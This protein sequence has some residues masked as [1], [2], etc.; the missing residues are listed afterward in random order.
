MLEYH[1]LLRVITAL[2]CLFALWI[3][4]VG[5]FRQSSE[6]NG[7]TIDVWTAFFG[8]VF[9]GFVGAVEALYR[10][11]SAGPSSILKL[12]V[13]AITIRALL[14]YGSVKTDNRGKPW[15]KDNT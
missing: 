14:R 13:V 6:W 3:L 10:G 2:G 8:W 4:G 1:V 12:L 15:K 9:L 11:L 7:K 5:A